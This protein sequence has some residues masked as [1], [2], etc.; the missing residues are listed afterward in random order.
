VAP[1]SGHGVCIMIILYTGYRS[2]SQTDNK[3]L[4]NPCGYR[5][6]DREAAQA[7]VRCT[8]SPI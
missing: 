6:Y 2:L 8:G 4:W 1:F 5:S 7:Q 3:Q